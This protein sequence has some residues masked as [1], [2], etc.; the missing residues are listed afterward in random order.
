MNWTSTYTSFKNDDLYAL[1]LGI[2]VTITNAPEDYF[3]KHR[4]A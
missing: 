3:I 2:Q 4:A 1:S